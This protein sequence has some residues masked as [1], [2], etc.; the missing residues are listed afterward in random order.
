[1]YKKIRLCAL[2]IIVA[3]ASACQKDLT[4][5]GA[6][7]FVQ[8]ETQTFTFNQEGETKMVDMAAL[9]DEWQVENGTYSD[10][11]SAKK[12]GNML[13]LI[14][15]ANE[16]AD[17]RKAQVV[18][19]TPNGKQVL[20]ITQF[21]S[22]PYITVEGSNGTAIFS[23]EA[24]TAVEMNVLS[25]SE[26][27][28]VEQVDKEKNDWLTY[29]V[30][31]KQ[32]KLKLNLTAIERNSQWAQTSRS[33]KLFLTNGN[34]HF[35]LNVTQNGYVQFQFPVW[36]IENFD[37]A[38][39]TELEAQ[40]NNS[41]DKAFEIDSLLPFKE[42]VDKIYYAFHSPGEQSPRIFYM[43]NYMTKK[44]FSAWLKAPKGQTFQKESYDP[45]LKQNNFML[46]NKQRVETETQYYCEEEDVTRLMHVYNDPMN[47]KM[48]GGIY[49]S[50]CMK[51]V[52]SSNNI[53]LGS[54]GK[55]TSFPVFRSSLLHNKNFKLKEVIEFEK[56]RGMKPDFNN[57]FN[58]EKITTTTEDPLCKYSR[59]LFVPENASYENG[60]LSNV[61]Y[62]FNWQGATPEDLDA[63]LVPDAELSGTVG[64]CHMFYMGSDI[65][66]NREQEGTPGVYEWYTYTL[67][68]SIRNVIEDKGYTFFRGDGNGFVTFFR[69]EAD[70]IDMRPQETR[71]VITYYKSKHYVDQIKKTLNL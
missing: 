58:D 30:D 5:G 55:I 12:V 68:V 20:D 34:K 47:F 38:R 36:D 62:Y 10:W 54:N 35:L 31:I 24:H 26:N 21:G 22:E 9:G 15:S 11:L 50:A 63:G 49:K 64:L 28:R 13:E 41:R 46:G 40:R 71:T 65:I 7:K 19:I 69:G 3:L 42:D 33:E 44:I 45:W 39:V 23:H 37:L 32:H 43:P 27:W 60:S 53:K 6:E 48:Y 25:N 17:E 14:A 67:P 56:K 16:G 29:E 2:L 66:Y 59:L 57:E 70:L 51:Y 4:L 52:V 1:M 61:I 18:V 8:G